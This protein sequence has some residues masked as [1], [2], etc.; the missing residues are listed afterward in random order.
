MKGRILSAEVDKLQEDL[1]RH[2]QQKIEEILES[3]KKELQ[4]SMKRN[5]EELVNVTVDLLNKS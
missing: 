4:D 1:I 3:V 2:A 5:V